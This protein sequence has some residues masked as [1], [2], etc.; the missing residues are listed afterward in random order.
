LRW[1]LLFFHLLHNIYF[2]DSCEGTSGSGVE[3]CSGPAS[4]LRRCASIAPILFLNFSCSLQNTCPN[5]ILPAFYENSIF[6]ELPGKEEIG[7]LVKRARL[8]AYL[9]AKPDILPDSS[10]TASMMKEKHLQPL[11]VIQKAVTCG[12]T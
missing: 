8:F 7:D 2:D 6:E 4:L 9:A 1:F 12:Q 11:M 5:E 10:T 3:V